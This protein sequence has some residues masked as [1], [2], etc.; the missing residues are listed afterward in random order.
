MKNRFINKRK[1][2]YF[3]KKKFIFFFTIFFL[4]FFYL[5]FLDNSKFINSSKKYIEE[6]LYNIEK[7]LKKISTISS[8]KQLKKLIKGPICQSDFRAIFK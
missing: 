4:S 8:D 3:N 2:N 7:V 5:L 6:Y 1:K